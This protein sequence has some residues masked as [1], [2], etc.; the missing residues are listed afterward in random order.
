MN[1]DHPDAFETEL[2]VKH[3]DHLRDAQ[4]VDKPVYDYTRHRRSAT[5]ERVEPAD[6]ILLEGILVLEDAGLRA[7]MDI[8]IYIDTDADERFMRR[9]CRDI[10]ER[11]RT[12]ESVVDQYR[13]TVKP[14]HL[15]FVEPSKRYADIIIPEGAENH[16]AL[17]LVVTKIRSVLAEREQATD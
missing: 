4:S 8:K 6:I 3:L 7:R 12:V 9:L 10:N 2:L 17:D 11:G 15:R 1:Y 5:T 14:M 13:E 16:V